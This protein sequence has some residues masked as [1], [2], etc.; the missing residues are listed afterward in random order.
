MSNVPPF[1]IR[2]FCFSLRVQLPEW[3]VQP[4]CVY[5][6]IDVQFPADSDVCFYDGVGMCGLLEVLFPTLLYALVA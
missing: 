1:L 2:S 5:S 6:H 3:S 4:I